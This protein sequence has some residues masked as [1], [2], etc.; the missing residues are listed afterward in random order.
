MIETAI[1]LVQEREGP[2]VNSSLKTV[3][4]NSFKKI[5]R[6]DEVNQSI[7]RKRS[8]RQSSSLRVNLDSLRSLP[9]PC[10]FDLYG[11]AH[12]ILPNSK[13][14]RSARK[15]EM[16]SCSLC[17]GICECPSYYLAMKF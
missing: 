10:V 12:R 2:E 14:T 9:S 13:E 15:I 17:H 5:G 16:S 4:S 8:W 7:M 1:N 11:M 6:E 3:V